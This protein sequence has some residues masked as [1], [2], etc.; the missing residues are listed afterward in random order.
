[1]LWILY[2]LATNGHCQEKLYH[3]IRNN[4]YRNANNITY[5]KAIVK[6]TLRLYPVTY[7]TSRIL[8]KDTECGGY[9]LPRGT[10]VQANLYGMGRNEDR[11]RNANEFIPERWLGDEGRNNLA[12]SNW[13]F[14]HGPRFCLGKRLAEEEI[15]QA[16]F[17]VNKQNRSYFLQNSTIKYSH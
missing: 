17:E 5:L 13:I 4:D 11:F 10:H 14:G 12:F 9:E 1:M 2:C 8:N 3:E 7:A 15:Y 16:V 6:E